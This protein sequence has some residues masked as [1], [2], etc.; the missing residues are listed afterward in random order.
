MLKCMMKRGG[1]L[2]YF[3]DVQAGS[4]TLGEEGKEGDDGYDGE[5]H[6]VDYLVVELCRCERI[7]CL[8]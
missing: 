6:D 2:R 1:E 8:V 4:E 7:S 5:I 3:M